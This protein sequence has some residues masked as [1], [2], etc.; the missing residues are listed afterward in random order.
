MEA[1]VNTGI[2]A[3]TYRY[4]KGES[5][6]NRITVFGKMKVADGTISGSLEL[7]CRF[8]AVLLNSMGVDI[9]SLTQVDEYKYQQQENC[10]QSVH[11]YGFDPVQRGECSTSAQ[12]RNIVA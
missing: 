6:R 11:L 5:D 3:K 7:L 4:S 2:G 1:F 10:G 9:Q 8:G 12:I